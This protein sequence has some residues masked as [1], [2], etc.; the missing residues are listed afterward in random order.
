MV[1]TSA[2]KGKT[3]PKFVVL[4]FLG[5]SY[6]FSFFFFLTSKGPKIQALEITQTRPMCVLTARES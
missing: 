6:W 5:A 1:Q 3:Y 4:F 2:L